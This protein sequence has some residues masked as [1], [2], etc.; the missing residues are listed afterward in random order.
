MSIGIR[1]LKNRLSHYLK[2]VKKGEKLAISERGRIIAYITPAGN[3]E[4][5]GVITL[6]SSKQREK[7][8]T[9]TKAAQTCSSLTS[10]KVSPHT[11]RH[12]TAMHLLQSGNDITTVKDWMGHADVN[13]THAYVEID[14]KMK[15]R[16]LDACQPP[17]TT[18][19]R[20][21]WLKPDILEWLDELSNKAGIMCSPGGRDFSKMA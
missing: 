10:K 20:P 14:M 6:T 7:Y 11:V 19:K 8:L 17:Q 1:E 2:I 16:A 12:T 4:Y 3:A 18:K 9:F 15:R 21:R 5:D 13:T